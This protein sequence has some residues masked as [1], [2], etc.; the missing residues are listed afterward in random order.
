MNDGRS[1]GRCALHCGRRSP[2]LSASCA[3]GMT[4]VVA[5]ALL[6][7]R[8]SRVAAHRLDGRADAAEQRDALACGVGARERVQRDA[9]TLLQCGHACDGWR[10][11]C[12]CSHTCAH[13]AALAPN[14]RSTHG[15]LRTPQCCSAADR[16]P[17]GAGVS[18]PNRCAD[19]LLTAVALRCVGP[20]R[21]SVG[22]GRAWIERR[23]GVL[24]SGAAL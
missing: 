9:S 19:G 1:I 7:A 10:C 22:Q 4:R 18:A 13:E 2:Q 20:V 6:H 16:R 15:L 23:V 3:A 8:G 5:P 17:S 21:A 24:S 14:A 12:A 11:V